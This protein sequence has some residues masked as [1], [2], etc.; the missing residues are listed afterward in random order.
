[1]LNDVD[2]AEKHSKILKIMTRYKHTQIKVRRN[3]SQG[4]QKNILILSLPIIGLG[5]FRIYLSL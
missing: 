1:M 2:A 5:F 4:T 3:R